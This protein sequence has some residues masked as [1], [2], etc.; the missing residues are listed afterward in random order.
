M[1]A[2]LQYIFKCV[3]TVNPLLD[4]FL[5]ARLLNLKIEIGKSSKINKLKK[6]NTFGTM[7]NRFPPV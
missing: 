7:Q 2:L 1:G 5:E 3:V 4:D 6:S